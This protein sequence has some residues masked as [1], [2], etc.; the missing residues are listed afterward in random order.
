MRQFVLLILL[1]YS[2]QMSAQELVSFENG[3][4]ADANAINGNF[5]ALAEKLGEVSLELDRITSA[6]QLD[7]EVNCDADG[8]GALAGAIFE[9]AAHRGR[10]YITATGTCGPVEINDGR[11]VIVGLNGLTINREEGDP[12]SG[13]LFYVGPEAVVSAVALTIDG[14][15][16]Q[17]SAVRVQGW[18]NAAFFNVSNAPLHSNLEVLGGIVQAFGAVRLGDDDEEVTAL[19]VNNGGI[20]ASVL[21]SVFPDMTQS[22]VELR[23]V[24]HL[25]R[26]WNGGIVALNFPDTYTNAVGGG[27]LVEEGGRLLV[28]SG[29]FNL[30]QGLSIDG[31]ST[32]RFHEFFTD[33]EEQFLTSFDGDISVSRASSALFRLTSGT[34]SELRHRGDIT[35]TQGSSLQVLGEPTAIQSVTLLSDSETSENPGVMVVSSGSS[36]SL[37]NA[38]TNGNIIVSDGNLTVGNASDLKLGLPSVKSQF[39]GV[40]LIDTLAED[41]GPNDRVVCSSGG[42]AWLESTEESLC[43][44]NN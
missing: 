24:N 41:H 9:N 17:N 15:A 14:T 37:S 25:V 3:S 30:S 42:G 39:N 5:D 1:I 6:D 44:S 13:Y 26:A 36:A 34:G 38:I 28:G 19:S 23:G 16:H 7:L 11:V 18:L 29:D 8:R 2:N 21:T 12:D 33:T 32:A 20:F 27:M 35:L 10:L 4:L 43:D 40:V 31:T 22:V